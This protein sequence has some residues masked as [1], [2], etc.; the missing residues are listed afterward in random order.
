MTLA[1]MLAMHTRK[2]QNKQISH[3]TQTEKKNEEEISV[4]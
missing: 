3:V 4:N 2:E 1:K